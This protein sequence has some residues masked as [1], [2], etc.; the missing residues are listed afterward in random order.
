MS[1][2]DFPALSG[3]TV[4]KDPWVTGDSPQ[5]GP[6]SGSVASSRQMAGPQTAGYLEGRDGMDSDSRVKAGSM[7]GKKLVSNGWSVG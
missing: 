2:L 6:V 7:M 1:V 3:Q 5:F 4:E